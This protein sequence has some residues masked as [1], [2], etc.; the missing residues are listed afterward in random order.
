MPAPTPEELVRKP[1]IMINAT[2]ASLPQV[3]GLR[4][5]RGRWF[6]DGE[7][8]AV[9]ND[10]LARREMP[11]RDPIGKRIQVS[12]NGPWLTIVGV[13]ADLKYSQLDAAAEPEV[14]VPYASMGR[15]V[16]L[17]RADST[18]KIPCLCTGLPKGGFGGRQDPGS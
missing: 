10:S 11:G 8:A 16:R 6:T 4:M 7:S 1:P 9:L 15:P 13:V 12:E 17:H 14:Y 5:L 3:M 18:A 2:S